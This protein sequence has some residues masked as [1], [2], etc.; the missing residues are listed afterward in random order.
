MFTC[1]IF[2]GNIGCAVDSASVG[3]VSESFGAL[4]FGILAA[5]VFPAELSL[6]M[7]NF[8]KTK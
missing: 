1:L 6:G 4:R 8:M 2:A 5:A 7:L 3:I